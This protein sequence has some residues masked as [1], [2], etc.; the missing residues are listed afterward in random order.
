MSGRTDLRARRHVNRSVHPRLF[1][2][3]LGRQNNDRAGWQPARSWSAEVAFGLSTEVATYF[4]HSSIRR[5]VMCVT[6]TMTRHLA[7]TVVL[8]VLD[9]MSSVFR[10]ML[11][12][13]SPLVGI[14]CNYSATHGVMWSFFFLDVSFMRWFSTVLLLLFFAFFL[15]PVLAWFL[16]KRQ[17]VLMNTR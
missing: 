7:I 13:I 9:N 15:F 16:G 17:T 3:H 8:V 10:V 1:H 2:F 4:I 11:F 6:S 14:F 5:S 12:L